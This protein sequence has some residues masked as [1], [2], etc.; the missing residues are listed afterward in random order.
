MFDGGL[1]WKL[2]RPVDGLFE[3][4]HEQRSV[5][6]QDLAA[7]EEIVSTKLDAGVD[8]IQEAKRRGTILL[9]IR[10][11][12]IDLEDKSAP[13]VNDPAGGGARPMMA[14][15][16]PMSSGTGPRNGGVPTRPSAGDVGVRM[17]ANLP[18]VNLPPIPG[19]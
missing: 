15:A 16:G 13:A 12:N 4:N 7:A 14:P 3:Y 8:P 2:A 9:V 17:P 19:R 10:M 1:K 5:Q 6:F 11:G 18:P